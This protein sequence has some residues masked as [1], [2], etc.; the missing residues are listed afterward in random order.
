MPLSCL[1]PHASLLL[2]RSAILHH[3]LNISSHSARQPLTC[4]S[5]PSRPGWVG[6][7]GGNEI[8]FFGREP[9]HS[10]SLPA[11]CSLLLVARQ[12]RNKSPPRTHACTRWWYSRTSEDFSVAV[13]AAL[14]RALLTGSSTLFFEVAVVLL[15]SLAV[16]CTHS[17]QYDL[18]PPPLSIEFFHCSAHLAFWAFTLKS[19]FLCCLL[20]L[21][22]LILNVCFRLSAFQREP[23]LLS[24][25]F[26]WR[27]PCRGLVPLAHF[28]LPLKIKCTQ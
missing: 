2:R 3:H 4:C 25:V 14:L 6:G 18:C 7:R 22:L 21:L 16:T 27:R 26:L 28:Y 15:M 5:G 24:A 8:C 23:Q 12:V 17:Y 9:T 10:L 19:G 11:P 13:T 20:L 1:N